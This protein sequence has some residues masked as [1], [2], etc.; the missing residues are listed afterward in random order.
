MARLSTGLLDAMASL[1]GLGYLMNG[2]AIYVFEGEAP[3]SADDA[4]PSEP[5]AAI[6]VEGRTFVPETDPDEAGIA[7]AVFS[8][9]RVA[10]TKP[11]RIVGRRDGIASWWRWCWSG[12]DDLGASAINPRVDGDVG[13]EMIL[14]SVSISPATDEEVGQFVFSLNPRSS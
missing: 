2:G 14:K 5:I 1:Y 4:A 13:D 12:P 10:S 8:P 11:L 7:L 6:T 3:P 9:G